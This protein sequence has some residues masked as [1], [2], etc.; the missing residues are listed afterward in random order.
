MDIDFQVNTGNKE[1]KRKQP[2]IIRILQ[3]IYCCAIVTNQQRTCHQDSRLFINKS[4]LK[5]ISRFTLVGSSICSINGE[6]V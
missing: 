2:K 5:K 4:N 6:D 1:S 3:Y